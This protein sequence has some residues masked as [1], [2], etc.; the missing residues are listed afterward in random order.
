MVALSERVSRVRA[1]NP[2]PM[3]LSG[4]NTYVVRVGD[5]EA[6]VIDP[7]PPIAAHVDAIEAATRELGLQVAAILVTHGHPDHFPAAAPLARRTGAPVWAHANVRFA[8]DRELGDRQRLEFAGATLEIIE[9]P[10]HTFDH[11][12]FNL[13]EEGALFTGDVILGHGTV[14]IAPPGGAMRP[15]QHTLERLLREHGD[16]HAIY[17]GHGEAIGDPR[18][19]IVEYIEHRRERERELIA[20]LERGA[21]TIPD[22]VRAIYAAVD[23]VLWPAAARQI[24]AYLLA[25][26]T[27]TRVIPHTLERAPTPQEAGILDPDLGRIADPAT[28]ELVRAEL[29]T[30]LELPLVEYRLA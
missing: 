10:G 6:V 30:S 25:L 9:A 15:Y 3:T 8:H 28:A 27:E 17:G 16:A 1:P 4:T 21:A 2:S 20:Q 14:V 29:G 24:L 22:L 12:V 13:C 23:S 11:L 26:E 5:G 7:G 18:A 19:K